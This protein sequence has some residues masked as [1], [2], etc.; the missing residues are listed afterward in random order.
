[1]SSDWGQT[2]QIVGCLWKEAR[3][4]LAKLNQL[5]DRV[6]TKNFAA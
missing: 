4:G 1:M 2:G 3:V 6:K 5:S